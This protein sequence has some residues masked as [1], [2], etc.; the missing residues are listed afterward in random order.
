MNTK[1][2]LSL[3]V[4]VAVAA[5]AV[6]GTVAYFSDTETSQG[7]IFTA[8][9]IDLKI[10]ST[11]SYNGVP[12]AAAT[13][14]EKD[15]VPT[16]DKFFD[17]ADIKPGDSGENTISLHVINNDAWVCASV[18]NLLN[19]ENGQTE[20][21]ASVDSTTGTNQGELQSAMVWTV[22]SDTNGDNIQDPG[23]TV[24]ASGHPVNGVLPVYDA[25]TGTPLTGGS[26]AYLG[27]SWSLPSSTGNEVQTD[28]MTGDISF[29]VVQSRNNLDFTCASLNQT[30]LSLE[31]KDANWDEI[32]NDPMYGTLTFKTSYSTFDYSLAVN[33]LDANTSYI[34]LYYADPWPGVNG[35][36]IGSSFM[37][38]GSGNA[39][40]S[41]NVE[42]NADLPVPADTNLGA[43]LWVVPIADWGGTGTGITNWEPTKYLH[44]HE[45]ISYDDTDI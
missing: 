14:A 37:T 26:T 21:E 6:G 12:V 3:V 29:Y 7:N 19:F 31:N 24:L 25:T 36:Q 22:W 35:I 28:S 16:A 5:I 33:G 17:F 10:D 44:E 41:D 45:L 15:L 8:G 34:L 18:S 20:P 32:L 13:W 30:T 40:V 27:V 1:I 23:E 42:L 43:K 2:I 38:D 39:S 4:I 9:A 11:A